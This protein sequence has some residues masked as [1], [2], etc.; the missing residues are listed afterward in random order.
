MSPLP[1]QNFLPIVGSLVRCNG[2]PCLE[3]QNNAVIPALYDIGIVQQVHRASSKELPSIVQV[4]FP[5]RDG[6][7]VVRAWKWNF[8]L[9][10][11][12]ADELFEVALAK[13]Q[14]L[15]QKPQTLKLKARQPKPRQEKSRRRHASKG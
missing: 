10:P 15:K 7:S 13:P 12:S 8:S 5:S 4:A 2:C 1:F 9:S 6:Q 11:A 3:M 14:V